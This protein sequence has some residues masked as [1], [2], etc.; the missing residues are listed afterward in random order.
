MPPK[1]V[2]IK[3]TSRPALIVAVG[4]VM[5]SVLVQITNYFI[6]A[7]GS[8]V[9]SPLSRGQLSLSGDADLGS[10]GT[11]ANAQCPP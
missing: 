1:K 2:Q 9:L 4:A 8:G 7:S 11:W 3:I 10:A 6:V 5:I